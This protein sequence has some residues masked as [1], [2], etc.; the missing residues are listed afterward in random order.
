[1][2]LYFTGR[3]HSDNSIVLLYPERGLLFAVDFIPV[4]S[5]PFRD[6]QDS[7]LDEWIDSLNFVESRLEFDRLVPGH[8]MLGTKDSVREVRNYF[9]DLQDAIRDARAQGLMDNSEEM[10]AAVRAALAPAYGSWANW[11]MF[12]PLNIQG[13]IRL[14]GESEG[15]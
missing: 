11:E 6:L 3:N 13:V 4:N 8:G 10:V 7:Y 5:L 12:L 14:W 9:L 2:E 15:T 1:V